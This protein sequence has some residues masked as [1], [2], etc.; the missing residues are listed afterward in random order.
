M[1]K[2]FLAHFPGFAVQI[3]DD[4]PNEKNKN[5]VRCGRPKDFTKEQ[6]IE[7]NE[8][9]AGIFFTPN[10]FPSGRR[11]AEDCKGIN[12]WIVENDSLSLSEQYKNLA[13]SPLAPS[14]LVETKSSVHAYWLAKDGTKDNYKKIV[15]GLI[16]KFS[17]D[18]ACKDISRVFRVP[19]FKHM[20]DKTKPK[21]VEITHLAPKNVYTEDQMIKAFPYTEEVYQPIKQPKINTDD[22]WQ[23]LGSMDNRIMLARMSGFPIVNNEIIE[24]RKRSP[25]GEY[26]YVNGQMC[27]GWIDNQ[28]MIGSGKRGG[29]TWIQ[30]LG[31]YGKSKSEIARWAKDNIP[32]VQDWVREHE[33]TKITKQIEIINEKPI[34]KDYKLRY[35]WGT[36]ELDIAFPIIKRGTFT[37]FGAKRNSGKTTFTFDMACK[38]AELGHKVLYLSLEMGEEELKENIARKYAGITIEEELDYKIPKIKLVAFEKKL[39]QINSIENLFFKSIRRG[40]SITWDAIEECIQD[41]SDLVF[42]DNLDLIEGDEREQDNDRQKRITKRIMNFTANKQIPII[43]IHHYRKSQ[44]KKDFGSDELSGS[45]KIGDG[46]DV[47]IKIAR[48]NDIGAPYPEKYSSNLYVQ[49]G[50]GY[51]EA[52]R[53]VYFVKGTFVDEPPAWEDYKSGY[54]FDE[55]TTA[56]DNNSLETLTF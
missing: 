49:K 54:S 15:Q 43:L 1:T 5:L 25:E 45:G 7:L 37:V 30:W 51:D 20:K 6:I 21:L 29:P 11:R 36:R 40:G 19:G 32:E 3:F 26:I 17:G 13:E 56:I 9:G 2:D 28:G 33:Q 24:F 23:M 8:Q 44:I 22:F 10:S 39:K 4:N 46:A 47:I 12:A 38:N 55:I 52:I 16:S 14:F 35:T 41:T 18:Q 48:N 53:T 50:R 27:D 34:K 42:I 31:F